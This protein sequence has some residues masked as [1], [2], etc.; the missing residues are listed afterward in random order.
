MAR[1]YAK[2]YVSV[3]GSDFRDLS[4]DAQHLYFQLMSNRKLSAAGHVTV[5]P[6]QWANQSRDTTAA[7][8]ERALAELV[9]ARYVLVDNDTEE[10]L[11]RSFIRHDRGFGNKFLRKS[12]ETAIATIESDTLRDHARR[13][14]VSAIEDPQV[15]DS[16]Q[17]SYQDREQDSGKAG[18][19]ANHQPP[20]S[21]F[22]STTTSNRPGESSPSVPPADGG[23]GPSRRS[24]I[25]LAAAEILLGQTA[26]QITNPV[27]WVHTVAQ[28]LQRE[29]SDWLDEVVTAGNLTI[30]QAGA[31][32]ARRDGQRAEPEPVDQSAAEQASGAGYGQAVAQAQ[33]EGEMLDRDAFLAELQGRPEGWTSAAVGAYDATLAALPP[34]AAS[35]VVELRRLQ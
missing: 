22:N 35:N 6:R 4:R 16:E 28:R 10:L 31:Y 34:A 32:L 7:D 20:P 25:V 29:H 1:S 2:L 27:G 9:T 30:S 11:I 21:T 12:I 24:Q 13:E 8:I 5:Q 15:E 3:W 17:D 23:G 19:Q 14:L 26:G 18:W 33:I